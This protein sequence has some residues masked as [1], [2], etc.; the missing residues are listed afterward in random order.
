MASVPSCSSTQGAERGEPSALG[1]AQPP[2]PCH[3]PAAGGRKK[4][5]SCIEKGYRK[6][7]LG[8]DWWAHFP[9]GPIERCQ[10]SLFFG[11]DFLIQSQALWW[12]QHPRP[13]TQLGSWFVS[14]CPGVWSWHQIPLPCCPVPTRC[15]EEAECGRGGRHSGG[16]VQHQLLPEPWPCFSHLQ[17]KKQPRSQPWPQ[18]GCPKLS[19]SPEVKL[20]TGAG[21]H[22]RPPPVPQEHRV[23]AGRP[24][25]H[26][27]QQDFFCHL[28]TGAGDWG[29]WGRD[30]LLQPPCWA[31]PQL[32][33]GR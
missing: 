31:W 1:A 32:K 21:H 20:G 10:P 11:G 26:F 9:W 13:C 14:V 22:L 15:Q 16:D 23:C 28:G 24:S 3:C 33:G 4:P 12:L 7:G 17:P 5:L 18:P 8:S 30:V 19:I 27:L 6:P 2:A 25:L 29:S